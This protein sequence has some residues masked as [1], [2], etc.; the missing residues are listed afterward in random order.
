MPLNKKYM[1]KPILLKDYILHNNIDLD[2][3][4]K[5]IDVYEKEVRY[6]K[7][8]ICNLCKKELNQEDYNLFTISDALAVCKSHREYAHIYFED[9]AQRAY[10]INTKTST[11]EDKLFVKEIYGYLIESKINNPLDK[12]KEKYLINESESKLILGL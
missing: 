1:E 3:A 2:L 12:I 6:N 10:R 9:L 4:K 5:L 7:N 8:C 11:E